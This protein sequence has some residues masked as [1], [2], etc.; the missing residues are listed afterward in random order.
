M[1]RQ[2]TLF[3]CFLSLI[4]YTQRTIQVLDAETKLA[5]PFAKILLDNG[6]SY[7]NTE[8]NGAASLNSDQSIFS[9][10]AFGY[11]SEKINFS[12]KTIYLKPKSTE[13]AE[14]KIPKSL[15][16]KQWTEG[17][18]KKE[19]VVSFFIASNI[20]QRVVDLFSYEKNYPENTFIKNIRFLTDVK[21]QTK[22]Q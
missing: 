12:E 7:I 10:E 9:V 8:E 6:K 22:T 15:N 2:I 21:K 3:F 17:K 1:K 13:I 14:V 19:F 20:G 5:I 16:T 11:I 4:F 18:I